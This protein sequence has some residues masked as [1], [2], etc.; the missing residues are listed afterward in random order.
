MKAETKYKKAKEYL[1]W[2]NILEGFNSRL[3][4]AEERIN[5]LED[6]VVKLTQKESKHMILKNED[7]LEV[8]WVNID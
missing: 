5:D 3:N 7:G 1:K 8:L 2:K 4:E 6:K